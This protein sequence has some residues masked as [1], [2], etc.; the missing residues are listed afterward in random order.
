MLTVHPGDKAAAYDRG[1]WAPLP[2]QLQVYLQ[3]L[4]SYPALSRLAD[5]D[6]YEETQMSVEETRRMAEELFR[7]NQLVA[8]RSLPSPP[9]LISLSPGEPA[10]EEFG[11]KG[12]SEFCISLSSVLM[13][14]VSSGLGI[15]TVGD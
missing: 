6:P 5:C 7:L 3:Q 1:P 12:L 2:E 8:A 10:D 13:Q 15:V 9:N 14:G 11:W 4:E